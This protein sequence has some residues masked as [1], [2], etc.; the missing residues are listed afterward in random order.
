M[1]FFIPKKPL[2]ESISSLQ[3]FLEKKDNAEITSHIVINAKDN[4]IQLKATDKEI[5]LEISI[6]N[7]NI[8]E[9]GI[10]TCNGKKFLDIVRI[11]KEDEINI[12]TDEQNL[13]IKQGRSKYKLPSFNSDEFPSFP[14]LEDLPKIDINS[15]KLINGFKKVNPSIATNN[16]KFELNG[17]L[18]D[19]RSSMINIVSTDTKRLAVFKIEKVSEKLLSIII[20]KKAITE[21]Q[22]IFDNNIEIFYDKTNLIIK[23]DD[24]FFFTK[25]I[26]G[27]FPDYERIIPRDLKYNFVLPKLPIIEAIR[28]VNILFPE[29]II[30]FDKNLISFES[31]SQDSSEAKTAFEINL[32]LEEKFSV[33]FNS[34]YLIDFISNIETDTFNISFNEP[35]SPFQLTSDNFL[36]IIM[37]IIL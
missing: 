23:N 6:N 30:T 9:E 1:N 34:R 17:A 26:N 2:E 21:I 29:I 5:G 4:S 35:S 33:A 13:H 32:N 12:F 25:V 3:A 10:T 36:T 7:I 15:S 27:K 24:Y 31:I 14:K 37:P 8:K 19:I 20:P 22:K 16:P 18:I 11:L 28:Q